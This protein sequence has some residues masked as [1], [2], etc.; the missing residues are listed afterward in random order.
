[1]LLGRKNSTGA[2]VDD[3][4]NMTLGG[5]PDIRL[6]H[7]DRATGKSRVLH[8]PFTLL[9]K[10]STKNK[11]DVTKLPKR[12]TFLKNLR[13]R[14]SSPTP[15]ICQVRNLQVLHFD[16]LS[17]IRDLLGSF[18]LCVNKNPAQRYKVF[19]ATDDDRY[20]KMCAQEW[21]QQTYQEL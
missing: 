20:V 16:I 7:V 11:M 9:R 3:N 10:H 5:E 6:S 2:S 15:I 18:I 12:A 13:A 17:Q 21:Y 1:M 19:A 4:D 14:V 8:H